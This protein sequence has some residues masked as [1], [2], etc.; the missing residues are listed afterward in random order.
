MSSNN[1]SGWFESERVEPKSKT[2]DLFLDN[3]YWL[4][5]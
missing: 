2:K 3:F 5:R 1:Y 4:E